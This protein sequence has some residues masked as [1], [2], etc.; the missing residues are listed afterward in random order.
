MSSQNTPHGS[1]LDSA[2]PLILGM[3]GLR[4]GDLMPVSKVAVDAASTF[5]D[6]VD[7]QRYGTALTCVSSI[8]SW[9]SSF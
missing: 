8:R 7:Q 6:A 1:K 5:N 3:E 4:P 9:S 2:S